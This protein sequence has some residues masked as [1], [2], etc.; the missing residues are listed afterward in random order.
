MLQYQG[1]AIPL[2]DFRKRLSVPAPLRDDTRTIILDWDGGK[3]GVVVDAVTEVM[4]VAATDVTQP[5]SIVRGLAA[6]YI[7]GLVVKDKRTI[8]VLNTGKLLASKEKIALQAA[9][10]TTAEAKV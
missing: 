8:V 6:E 5:H 1:T 7:T 9:V 2:I 4:Q 10:K 3:L